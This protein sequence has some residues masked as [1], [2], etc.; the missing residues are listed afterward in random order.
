M[1]VGD[2]YSKVTVAIRNST[3]KES[4]YER[5]LGITFDKKLSFR[6]YVEDLCKKAN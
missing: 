2:K 1:I 5:L 3:I 6:K 4:E